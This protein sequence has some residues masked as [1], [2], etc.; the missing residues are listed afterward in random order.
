[1]CQGVDFKVR[2][3]T[4]R[5]QAVS[6]EMLSKRYEWTLSCRLNRRE[7]LVYPTRSLLTDF[8]SQHKVSFKNTRQKLT[9]RSFRI[10]VKL[11]K[12]G[13]TVAGKQRKGT[14]L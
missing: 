11:L 6:R 4:S 2:K 13:Q 10:A 1:M 7:P 3:V 9:A 14:W 12:F 8:D 5:C